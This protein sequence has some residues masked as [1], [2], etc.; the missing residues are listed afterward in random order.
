MKSSDSLLY[1]CS[2]TLTNH[3]F[4]SASQLSYILGYCDSTVHIVDPLDNESKK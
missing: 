1:K 4:P 3:S 2:V